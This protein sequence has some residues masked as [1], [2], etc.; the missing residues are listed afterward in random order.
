VSKGGSDRDEIARLLGEGQ[1]R[2]ALGELSAGLIHEV[3]NLLTSIRGFAQVG[4]RKT[5]D[6]EAIAEILATIEQESARCVVS[7]SSFLQFARAAD[8]ERTL[9]DA[10]EIVHSVERLVRH[11]LAINDVVLSTQPAPAPLWMHACGGEVSQVLVNLLLNAQQAMP[12]GGGATVSVSRDGDDVVIT[13]ADT[14]PGIDAETAARV[15][16]P[17]FTTKPP[18][19]GTGIGL[20][21]SARIAAAHG[22]SLALA[23][24]DTGACF[25]LRLP[26]HEDSE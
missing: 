25:A 2:I 5:D 6:A 10:N 7:L 19:E 16:E 11:Q 12:G 1:K 23:P 26:A 4:S 13:V 21:I 17:F 15:F 22:G 9:V 14:G 24:S 18:S 8:G 20:S 3:R